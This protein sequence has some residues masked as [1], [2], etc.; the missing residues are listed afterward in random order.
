[1]EFRQLR[2]VVAVAEESSFARAAARENVAPSTLGE[3]IAALEREIGDQLFNRTTR[4]VSLTET[5]QALLVE[6]RACLLAFD[7]AQQAARSVVLRQQGALRLG[8]PITGNP[9]QLEDALQRCSQRY[10]ALR[11]EARRGYSARH[12]QALLAGRLDAAVIFGAP[13][14]TSGLSYQRLA[15]V[16]LQL[17]CP[18]GSPLAGQDQVNLGQLAGLSLIALDQTLSPALGPTLISEACGSPTAE[19]ETADSLEAL[20]TTVAAGG[21]VALLPEAVTSTV[22]WRGVCYRSL[23]LASSVSILES[24]GRRG[25]PPPWLPASW[26]KRTGREIALRA[27]DRFAAQ[28]VRLLPLASSVC[29]V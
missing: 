26:T 27:I 2:Y 10:P 4:R 1:M 9:Q 24:V 3:Q 11:V 15:L 25:L 13:E 23:G 14:Q 21:A 17:V 16:E 8:V 12:V 18:V 22:T 5:G 20:L 7:R 29:P 6:A 28:C 19:V